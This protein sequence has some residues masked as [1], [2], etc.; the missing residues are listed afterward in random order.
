M[1]KL[2]Y[3]PPQSV[4]IGKIQFV[5]Q[6][7]FYAFIKANSYKTDE[8]AKVLVNSIF[9]DSDIIFTFNKYNVLGEIEN[10]ENDEDT[11]EQFEWL[12]A[13]WMAHPDIYDTVAFVYVR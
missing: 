6:D 11:K 9:S 4:H 12:W 13:F 5:D 10:T 3:N 2:K 7:D 8:E 1:I